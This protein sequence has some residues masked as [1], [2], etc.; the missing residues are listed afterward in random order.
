MDELSNISNSLTGGKIFDVNIGG[1]SYFP[2]DPGT[3]SEEEANKRLTI[4]LAMLLAA[5]IFV[6][7]LIAAKRSQNI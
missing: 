1:G 3:L 4:G 2:S 7:V 5:M 6:L